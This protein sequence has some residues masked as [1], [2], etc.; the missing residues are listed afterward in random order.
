MTYDLRSELDKFGFTKVS[1][2]ISKNQ[3]E[4]LCSDLLKLKISSAVREKNGAPYG[5]RNLLNLAP[6]VRKLSESEKIKSLISIVLGGNAKPVRAI[7]FDKTP[8]A[9]WKVP[10]HQDL[11]I[12][13]REKR[14]TEGFSAWRKKNGTHHVQPPV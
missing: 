13:V 10:W 2:F 1:S 5:I 6:E 8:D 11:T 14:E 3:I 9:N 4:Q 7:F 12:A